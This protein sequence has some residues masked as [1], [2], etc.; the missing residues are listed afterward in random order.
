MLV[1]IYIFFLIFVLFC[2]KVNIAL[3]SN[4]RF[5]I[6][7]HVQVVEYHSVSEESPFCALRAKVTPSQRITEKPHQPWV[8]LDKQTAAVYCAHCTCMAG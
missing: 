6:S 8:Y 1:L 2:F 7:G 4:L 5:V 3:F